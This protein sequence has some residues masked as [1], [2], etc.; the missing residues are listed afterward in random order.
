MPP[1]FEVMYSETSLYGTNWELRAP[2]SI[3]Y[4][5]IDLEKKTA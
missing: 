4:M 2:E 3:R 1:L 5:E